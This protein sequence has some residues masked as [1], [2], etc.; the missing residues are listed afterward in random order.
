MR[1]HQMQERWTT[2]RQWPS[3]SIH[4]V[5][6]APDAGAT[7][8]NEV[9]LRCISAEAR[10]GSIEVDLKAKIDSLNDDVVSRMTK[11]EDMH[12]PSRMRNLE[13][14]V[15]RNTLVLAEMSG[16]R[17]HVLWNQT[18][19]RQRSPDHGMISLNHGGYLSPIPERKEST[20]LAIATQETPDI[21]KQVITNTSSHERKDSRNDS[22]QRCASAGPLCANSSSLDRKQNLQ[23]PSADHR[24]TDLAVATP[25]APDVVDQ[26]VAS[27]G[28]TLRGYK[29]TRSD[30]SQRS[31]SA[32]TARSD[33]LK[34]S[35]QEVVSA[36]TRTLSLS[37]D[38]G[39][40]SSGPPSLISEA[41]SEQ[42]RNPTRSSQRS[43][44]SVQTRP[45]E[46]QQQQQEQQQQQKP[47]QTQQRAPLQQ[48]QQ[49]PQQQ[50]VQQTQGQA[51]R[52]ASQLQLQQPPTQVPPAVVSSGIHNIVPKSSA[53]L[54]QPSACGSW[55]AAT[56]RQRAW[57][58]RGLSPPLQSAEMRT[59]S[60]QVAPTSQYAHTNPAAAL[61]RSA[62]VRSEDGK[63]TLM[64]G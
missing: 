7:D 4:T 8:Y 26:I 62:R 58:L 16:E 38:V 43:G 6:A 52:F 24:S 36:V 21:V 61:S 42:A 50:A 63:P 39:A 60:T 9:T 22:S 5:N 11:L 41:P 55:T 64:L 13:A 10:C 35:L 57:Q 33:D 49:K 37:L 32:G 51:S 29:P 27:L 23:P 15:K 3:A 17:K 48:S 18:A 28:K 46:Q 44:L 20:A 56:A 1:H 54:A 47:Q 2:T 40:S 53:L 45:L 30:S 25:Q 14:E 19:Q 31:A 12:L 59:R 34:N